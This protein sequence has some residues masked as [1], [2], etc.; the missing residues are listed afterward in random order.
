[1][2]LFFNLFYQFFFGLGRCP[3][4]AILFQNDEAVGVVEPHR[5]GGYVGHPNACAHGFDFRKI[6]KQQAFHLSLALDGFR[7]RTT[8]AEEGLHGD[9]ALI[10]FRHKFTSHPRESECGSQKQGS[11]RSKYHLFMTQGIQQQWV[12]NMYDAARHTVAHALQAAF[13]PRQPSVLVAQW[14]NQQR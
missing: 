14:T 1:M 2:Q 8:G 3:F 6:L 12:I 11:G 4:A 10:E 9:V 7:E 5:V 13:H